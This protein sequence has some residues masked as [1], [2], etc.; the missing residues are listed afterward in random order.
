M[1]T[2]QSPEFQA[3]IDSLRR[4]VILSRT[5]Q[6]TAAQIEELTDI[7]TFRTSDNMCLVRTMPNEPIF[8]LRGKDK[9]GQDGIIGWQEGARREGIH[10]D[11]LE[12]SDVCCLEFDAYYSSLHPAPETPVIEQAVASDTSGPALPVQE[13]DSTVDSSAHLGAIEGHE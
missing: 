2:K 8:V 1:A 9:V 6:L 3:K 7:L 5:R 4:A 12:D 10:D 13:P 11:H